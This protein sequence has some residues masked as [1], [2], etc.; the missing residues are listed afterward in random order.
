MVS[1][2]HI[3]VQQVTSHSHS[4]RGGQSTSSRLDRV[5]ALVTVKVIVFEIEESSSADLQADNWPHF[6]LT[7]SLSND[8]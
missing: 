1:T 5:C 3:A 7:D 2:E 6:H 8:S 4:Q